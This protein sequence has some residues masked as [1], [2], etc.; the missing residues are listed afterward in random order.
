M[1][2]SLKNSLFWSAQN[3][4]LAAR[5][6]LP[7]AIGVQI[8]TMVFNCKTNEIR[9]QV[10][11]R[12]KKNNPLV[13]C[14]V[15][16]NA[17][18]Y[19]LLSIRQIRL[20]YPRSNIYVLDNG[21]QQVNFD[22]AK[23]GLEKFNNITFFSA[24]LQTGNL[25]TQLL[26][27]VKF[28]HSKG[29]QFLLDYSA[30]QSDKIA[31]FLDQDCILSNN[32][33]GLLVKF[34]KQIVLVGARDYLLVPKDYGPLRKGILRNYGRFVAAFF[35]ILQPKRIKRVLGNFSFETQ[36]RFGDDPFHNISFRTQGKILFLETQM[37]ETIPFLTRCMYQNITYAWHAWYSTYR[38]RWGLQS[39]VDN[40]PVSWLKEVQKLEFDYLSQIGINDAS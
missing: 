19:L 27:K 12:G 25:V 8:E 4:L 23:R 6:R 32:I 2:T 18:D 9:K 36:N 14:I 10:V 29:L 22:A 31:V 7:K 34:G 16:W 37:H 26:N 33:D 28:S 3:V 11:I 1:L 17:P 20:F 15:H 5:K 30:E 40:Y 38:Y 24:K 21:S 13:F 35:M 39:M